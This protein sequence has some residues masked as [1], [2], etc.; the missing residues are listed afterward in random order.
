MLRQFFCDGGRERVLFAW[1]GLLVFLS[2]QVFRAWLK[3]AINNWYEMFYDHLQRA[4]ANLTSV[5]E[6][7][8]A[9][10]RERVV[11]LLW[12]FAFIAAPA[13]VINPIAG[14]VRK[15][16]EERG[17]AEDLEA[18]HRA[19]HPLAVGAATEAGV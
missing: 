17:R 3:Y 16:C 8:L 9:V 1:I 5:D 2:H 4:G 19:A 7:E 13:V 11:A 10:S 18:I 14:L 6:D 15:D 12:E